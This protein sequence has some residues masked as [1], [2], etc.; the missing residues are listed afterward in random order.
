MSRRFL[1]LGHI[2][3]RAGAFMLS[4]TTML[5]AAAT[6]G[7]PG[8][9]LARDAITPSATGTLHTALTL[10]GGIFGAV[11]VVALLGFLGTTSR[12]TLIATIYSSALFVLLAP[13]LG[14]GVFLI[15]SLLR[16]HSAEF[17]DACT[18]TG[19]G[20]RAALGE[21]A[22]AFPNHE[23]NADTDLDQSLKAFCLKKLEIF[24]GVFIA[25]LVL[26]GIFQTGKS[27][28]LQVDVSS[29]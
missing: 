9:L 19:Q 26:A 16:N 27:R 18:S 3:I 17:L 23:A 13:A 28:G 20:F 2:P 22:N 10:P 1:G 25:L 29:G 7:I 11:A 21:A 6:A 12:S 4:F 8:F 15:V 24:K 5:T 14:S